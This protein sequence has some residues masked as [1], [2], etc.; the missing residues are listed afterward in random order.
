MPEI[1]TGQD[2]SF[3][4]SSAAEEAA[5]VETARAELYDEASADSGDG[6]ILGKYQ[7]VDDLAQAYQSLQAEYS[8]LKGGV[9]QQQDEEPQQVEADD[10]GDDEPE[11]QAP[12]ITEQQAQAIRE[13]VLR[14]A[15]GEQQY[16]RL[17]NWAKNNLEDG[18][19]NAFNAAL[20]KGDEGV[21]LSLLKG[22]QYD[23]M[24]A[25]G[26]E[27]R[28]SGGRAPSNEVKGFA[29]EAQAVQ[30]VNDPR[31]NDDPAYRR[32]VEQRIA[33]SRIFET[34]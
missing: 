32:E 12:R 5:R 19:V 9:P 7:S 2:G 11:A 1:I 8:R 33:V 6:L 22:L 30:A 31:Y 34:R 16:Q 20:E 29:S 27:P 23:F 21:I 24:M 13:N 26:Y 10:E 14:Q 17:A 18:R 3:A 28:L 4:D 25:N 15:G